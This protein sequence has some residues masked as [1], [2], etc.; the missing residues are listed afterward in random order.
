MRAVSASR[1]RN[2]V[3]QVMGRIDAGTP[4]NPKAATPTITFMDLSQSTEWSAL[5]QR[6]LKRKQ[7]NGKITFWYETGAAFGAVARSVAV[8]SYQSPKVVSV[9]AGIDKALDR[10]AYEHA[11]RAEFGADGKFAGRA[12]FTIANDLFRRKRDEIV[13]AVRRTVLDGVNW[14]Q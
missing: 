1:Y 3:V 14:G 8:G 11:L 4:D 9:F 7:K 6:S 12:L 5:S 13:E 10:E 2:G